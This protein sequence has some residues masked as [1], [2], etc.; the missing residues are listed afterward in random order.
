MEIQEETKKRH[1]ESERQLLSQFE[2][3]KSSRYKETLHPSNHTIRVKDFVV[4]RTTFK[5]I[6]HNHQ[7]QDIEATTSLID[8]KGEV[9]EARVSAGYCLNCNTFFIMESTFQNLRMKGTPICRISDEK[10]YLKN[11]AY[12]NGM[13]LAQESILMQY[14]YTV[15][16][17]QGLSDVNRRRILALLIDNEVLTRS[18]I[19]G[20]LGFFIN[21]RQH[22]N[23]YERA[24]SKWE[25]DLEYISE[26]KKGIQTLYGVNSICRKY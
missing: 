17:E 6:H 3:E 13:I 9:I 14:G 21:Q 18:D 8:R 7:V 22:Q 2:K 4:R 20:Y 10:T 16:Q 19:I 24:I 23:K 11:N 15:S 5:C 1:K 25:A 26:Y 12:V